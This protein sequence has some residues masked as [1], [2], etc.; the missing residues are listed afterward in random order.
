MGGSASRGEL[1]AESCDCIK[2]AWGLMDTKGSSPG[3]LT[4]CTSDAMAY[5]ITVHL[6][7]RAGAATR[8]RAVVTINLLSS[9]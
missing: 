2:R 1:D 8:S 4:W 6:P 9:F 5:P 7:R 3:T